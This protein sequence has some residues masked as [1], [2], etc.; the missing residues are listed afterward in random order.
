MV[1]KCDWC[2]VEYEVDMRN[3]KR[4][5][6]R[7]CSKTCAANKRETKNGHQFKNRETSGIWEYS[8]HPFSGV[9][10]GQD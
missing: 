3:F 2:K 4:G 7:C 6:G 1:R 10:L 5:W 8:E 9:G